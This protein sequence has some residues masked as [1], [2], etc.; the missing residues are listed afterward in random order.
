MSDKDG[1]ITHWMRVNV[2]VTDEVRAR[3]VAQSRLAS[4]REAW[5]GL[6]MLSRISDALSD[7][8][9]SVALTT[10]S[11][12]LVPEAARWVKFLTYQDGVLRSARTINDDL[13]DQQ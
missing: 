2:D 9:I 12:V 7:M 1:A 3:Q 13:D 10:V 6:N 4:E 11:H 8:D 5:S